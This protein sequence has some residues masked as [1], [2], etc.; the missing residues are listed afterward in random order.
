M[1]PRSRRNQALRCSESGQAGSEKVN[2]P[3]Q[4]ADCRQSYSKSTSDECEY[5]TFQVGEYCG[6]PLYEN[7]FGAVVCFD[8]TVC[9]ICYGSDA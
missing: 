2:G 3:Y 7:L 8:C 5:D 1:E 6:R 4:Q 9:T